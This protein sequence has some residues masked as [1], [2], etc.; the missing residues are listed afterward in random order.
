MAWKVNAGMH[1]YEGMLAKE[2]HKDVL[3][4]PGMSHTQQHCRKLYKEG[5]YKVL[6]RR[7]PAKCLAWQR[8]GM[9]AEYN[10]GMGFSAQVRGTM[11]ANNEAGRM[12]GWQWHRSPHTQQHN[13]VES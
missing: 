10:V 13:E 2:C 12:H 9:K 4:G 6:G 11:Q 3:N 8:L 1:V 5:A 7:M